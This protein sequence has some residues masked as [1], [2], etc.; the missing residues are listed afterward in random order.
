MSIDPPERE[1][2]PEKLFESRANLLIDPNA[3]VAEFGSSKSLSSPEDRARFHALRNWADL[4]I[5]GGR[6][7]KAEPY[8][9]STIPVHV[10]S[11]SDREISD[12]YQEFIELAQR[13]GRNLLIE[14]GPELLQ[15]IIR[16]G[17]LDHL[18]LTRT[19]RMSNDAT[20]PVFS[21]PLMREIE[22][23]WFIT[24]DEEVGE[25][26]FTIFSRSQ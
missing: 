25:D 24:S 20:S 17:A 2:C 18:H 4:I 16:A 15:Q 10:F 12:W 21:A 14:A 19:L 22:E 11:R 3:R 8:S 5:V 23:Q 7:F 9:G 6:T 26:R 1:R 13:Y